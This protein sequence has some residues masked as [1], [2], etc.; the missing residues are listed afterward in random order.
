MP[1]VT[2]VDA[3]RRRGRGGSPTAVLDD[4]PFTDAERRRIPA[5]T[6][7]SH[8]VFIAAA[9][10][11]DQDRSSYRLRF[12]TGEGE[13]PAC[14]HGT[15]AALALLAMRCGGEAERRAELHTT[16]RVFE[17]WTKREHDDVTATFD[18][19]PIS[20]RVA[21]EPE[22]RAIATALGLT[23]EALPAGACLASP[24][25]PR[26]L[27]PVRSRTVLAELRPDFPALRHACDRYGL[28]G[29]Y[30]YSIPDTDGR[31]AA[32]MFAPSIGV[33][34]DVANAN[35]TACLAAYLA[36]QGVSDIAVDMGDHLGHPST[37]IANARRGAS[38]TLIRLGGAAGIA[39]TVR[40]PRLG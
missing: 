12:F 11:E 24:G 7:T 13:L 23:S 8:A 3:C 2:I 37:I 27:L 9:D 39:R 34:E 15:V 29:C 18:P 38:G 6:G 17:G 36:D 5:A 35:S 25:R 16:S 30:A 40:L 4:A 31:A 10:G 1:E 28:L 26:L 14:G 22:L 19:G 20:P 33:P 32:R 21:G